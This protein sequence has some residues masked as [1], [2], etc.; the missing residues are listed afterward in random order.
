MMT[1]E[2]KVTLELKAKGYR[3]VIQITTNDKPFGEPLF[4]KAADE[5]GP[6]L[7]SFRQDEQAKIAWSK[8]IER[9]LDTLCVHE[10]YKGRGKWS[11]GYPATCVLC[12]LTF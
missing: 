2:L 12:G 7:R 6:L 11:A 4:L 9:Y 1:D 10:D 8:P 3:H 5:A